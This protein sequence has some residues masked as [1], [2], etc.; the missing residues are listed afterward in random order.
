LVTTGGARPPTTPSI[1]PQRGRPSAAEAVHDLS[2]AAAPAALDAAVESL[3]RL[4][5]G[6]EVGVF[7]RRDDD[8]L[9]LVSATTARILPASVVEPF[10]HLGAGSAVPVAVAVRTGRPV[11]LVTEDDWAAFPDFRLS[12][13]TPPMVC[14]ALPLRG[15]DDGLVLGALYALLPHGTPVDADTEAALASM[16][17]A[18]AEALDRRRLTREVGAATSALAVSEAR[19]R[20]LAEADL[21][22][23]IRADNERITDANDTFLAAIG[24]TRDELA[25]A[26]LPWPALTPP[27]WADTDAWAYVQLI[28]HGTC[29]PYEKEFLRPDGSTVTVL[30]ALARVSTE[31]FEAIGCVI[32][33]SERKDLERRER[34]SR[35]EVES[36]GRALQA[37]LLPSAR[38]PSTP[39][40]TPSAV[41]RPGD[42]RMMLGGDFYDVVLDGGRLAVLVGDVSGHGPEAAA[43][44]A[45]L[46]VAWRVLVEAGTPAERLL[47][48]LERLFLAERPGP[49]LFVTV[50]CVWL[51]ADGSGAE[52]IAAGHHAPLVVGPDGVPVTTE[53]P[54][55]LPLGLFDDAEWTS[56]V[57][58]LE[59][60]SRLLV[61]TDGLIEG[62]AVPGGPQRLGM[63]GLAALLAGR[64][65]LAEDL[66]ALLAEVSSAH[67][68]GLPDDVAVVGLRHDAGAPAT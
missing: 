35:A 1:R 5:G 12:V 67:G 64:P 41:Y 65:A 33:I 51:E 48:L 59:P 32:D 7:A 50:C 2:G 46:R 55:S 58:P 14:V 37:S 31:P 9:D 16:G 34:Q 27:R 18:C 40:W 11:L 53:L 61:F 24:R 44:G 22:G 29:P 47:P 28:T 54:G 68:G 15:S 57:L 36:L 4:L 62:H 52:I 42:E 38:L 66:T 13:P 23:I 39:A 30:M 6:V 25:G 45:A 21:V 17:A 8:G 20:S 56:V 3:S 19:L 49:D 43:M 60:G 63:D 10:N 26:G